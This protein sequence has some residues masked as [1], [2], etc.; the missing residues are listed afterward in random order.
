[1]RLFLSSY[2]AGNYPEKLLGLFGRGSRVAVVANAK[3]Y[4]SPHEREIK[5]QEVLDFFSELGLRPAEIDLRKY[6]TSQVNW[7][8]E[9]NKY[10]AVWLAG[11]NVFLLRRALR[12]SGLDIFLGN[13]VRR[14]EIIMGGESAGAIIMGPT[15][16]HS[17]MESED[18]ED[19]P[20]YVPDGYQKEVVWSGLNFISYIPV[21]HYRD[22]EY[23]NE[24]DEY[25]RR[26][27]QNSLPHKELTNDQAIIING[28]KEEFLE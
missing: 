22:L 10:T 25:I 23:G 26:L 1:V 6:F 19:S 18:H 7:E 16:M 2:R 14:N 4:K 13:K 8:Q 24:I 5:V 9:L 11:G 20:A 21:P 17:E 27:D 3:D 15:L 28:S 12:Y